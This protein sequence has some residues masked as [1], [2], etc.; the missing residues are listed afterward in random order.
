[1]RF[2]S[3]L[4]FISFFY[5]I[6][7]Q[8]N[9]PFTVSIE[10]V[11]LNYEQDSI[12]LS[13]SIGQ[14]EY[15]NLVGTTVKDNGDFKFKVKVNAPDYYLL[16]LADNQAINLIVKKKASIKVYGDAKN[17]FSF[18]NIVNDEDSK[19][20]MDFLR[21]NQNYKIK[22]DSARAELQA[23]PNKQQEIN[24][25][26]KPVF[27]NFIKERDFF[28]DKNQ[29]SPA[30]VAA[31]STYNLEQEFS[32]YE[33]TV[34]ALEQNFSKSPTVIKV[35][36]E[37]SKNKEKMKAKEPL[38][39]GNSV[40]EISM[41]SP[42]GEVLNLSDY[43]GK[44]VLIDFWAS[45][46]G[47]CRKENPN[48]VKTYEKYKDHGFDIFSVS[49]DKDKQRWVEAIEKDKLTWEG[50]VS[51]LKGWANEASRAYGISSIPFTVLIDK[52][53]KV[54][55]TNLRGAQLEQTLKSIFG[56]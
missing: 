5:F 33:K 34:K 38:A 16:R 10:G 43:K 32:K 47:P 17:F 13:R 2:L 41:E 23:N 9:S 15:E 55:A 39:P 24:A 35:V 44:V 37:Y 22:L 36:E 6:N 45:W 54:I 42:D 49:L 19:L 11:V 48:V 4:I 25:S 27:D 18:T 14:N 12:F 21:L 28:V 1:M 29:S 46:C 40:K 50:H 30:I 26:F 20:L 51:D 52:D 56:F 3:S 31:L 7:A 8:D 53:G